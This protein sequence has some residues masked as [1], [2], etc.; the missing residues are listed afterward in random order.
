LP[1]ENAE[2]QI[3]ISV[4]YPV[5]NSPLLNC[6]TSKRAP[7]AVVPGFVDVS[8][9]SKLN[10]EDAPVKVACIACQELSATVRFIVVPAYWFIRFAALENRTNAGPVVDLPTSPTLVKAPVLMTT[11]DMVYGCET[12]KELMNKL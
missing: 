10:S 4:R 11:V 12:A 8:V 1:E 3:P 6:P 2:D 9:P 5:M 7:N